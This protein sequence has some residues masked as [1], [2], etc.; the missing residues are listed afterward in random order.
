[1]SFK[2]FSVLSIHEVLK[3]L[4]TNEKGLTSVEAVSRLECCG[5]N[6]FR[7]SAVTW[8]QV[9][10]RQFKSPF[11]YLLVAAAVLAFVLGER[12]DAI[13]IAAFVVINVLIGF[14]QEYHSEKAVAMLKKMVSSKVLVCRDGKEVLLDSRELVPGDCVILKNGDRLQADL[15]WIKVDNLLVNESVLTGESVLVEKTVEPLDQAA[16][17]FFS[18]KNIGFSGTSVAAGRGLGIVVATGAEV[19]FNK[20]AGLATQTEA[21]GPF[22]KGIAE[23]S[24]FILRL[25][26]LTLLAVF[27]LNWLI[28]GG[29]AD[30][31]ELLI[32]S[33]ALAVS[34]IPEALPLVTTM[35]LSRGALRLA[36][37]K[38]VAKKLSA[39]EDLGSIDIL[40][41]DKTGTVTENLM[42][43]AG[44][45][46]DNENKCLRLSAL[47]AP[48][49]DPKTSVLRANFDGAILDYLS[50]DLR[51]QIR[52]VERENE[53]PFDPIR[54]W[55]SVV[56]E[57]DGK[58]ILIVRGA[59]EELIK[60]SLIKKTEIE[61]INNWVSL[62]GHQGNRVLAVAF[63]ESKKE[64]V[65]AEDGGL[66]FAGVVAF[67]D[68]VKATA[69]SAIA[70]ANKLGV[71]V[72]ILTGDS[73]EVAGSVAQKIGLIKSFD[74]VISGE[75][76]T[77]L[78]EAERAV[79]A[80]KY[81][82]F[83]R[84]TPEHKFLIIKALK[85]KFEVGFLGDG[86]NDAP[87]LKIAHVG[88]AV[89]D[90][91]DVAREAADL[92][93]LDHDLSVIVSGIR[94]GREIFANTSKYIKVTLTSNFGNFIAVAIATLLIDFLPM[95]PIQ[96]LLLNLL[97]DFPMIAIATDN[98]DAE[99]LKRPRHYN[100]REIATA[101]LVLGVVSTI[102]DLIFFWIFSR[103]SP[104]V[105][106]TNWFIASVLT[107]LILILSLR[108][109][110][111]FFR[112]KRPAT[113]LI[114]LA[115]IGAAVAIIIPI[116]TLGQKWFHF[117]SPTPE[118]LAIIF[119]LV[120]AY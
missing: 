40:C 83:A 87:A 115:L 51:S 41:T 118:Y 101:A 106:W 93:L 47:A 7:V 73:L 17:D 104:E 55:N 72:K 19:E 4:K 69:A 36:K 63:R 33:I 77:K 9:L 34:V 46:S 90:A 96:L 64:S 86:I 43:V 92:V 58:K 119:S 81:A 39:I 56:V 114:S 75:A 84:V 1:M 65:R 24:S 37:K 48:P 5:K 103:I 35:T 18:A 20:I 74:Q 120:L 42:R 116:T 10:L 12:I 13:M 15:R 68:P 109:K 91:S 31:P 57:E 60:L 99:E 26:L 21:P 71:Q 95:L 28:K 8:W 66:T 44:I 52:T 67:A 62:Q 113:V 30:I 16:T 23:F 50:E 53:I 61:K 117:V 29:S 76:W 111:P 79:A 102:F 70:E 105:L 110:K 88:L 38:V 85:E 6:E 14:A 3:H 112:A 108:T 89:D 11:L 25:I 82:V 94:E 27:L 97:S 22:E 45:F 32:F 100:V 80:L 107:E 54:R 2:N 49:V 78:P 98:V 59:P